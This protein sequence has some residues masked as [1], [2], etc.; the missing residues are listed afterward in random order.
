MSG[1]RAVPSTIELLISDVDG[2]LVT[3]NKHLT[4]RSRFAA[5]ALAEAGIRF[6][7][8]S[9]RPAIGLR[10]LIEPL[11]LTTPMGALNGGL[12][13]A[14]DGLVPIE[15]RILPVEVARR[16]ID[17]FAQN[18]ID[19]WLFDDHAWYAR[20]PSGPYVEHEQRTIQASP[21]IVE[22][23]DRSGLIDNAYKIVG[24]STDFERLAACEAELHALLGAEA[25]VARSQR[26]YLDI[27]HPEANKG[28]VVAVLSRQ[29]AIPQAAVACIGDGLNDIAMFEASALAVAMGNA[30]PAVQQRADF[31]TLS[32]EDD[33][34]AAAVERF[35][36]PRAPKPV[37]ANEGNPLAPRPHPA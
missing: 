21:V 15:E 3:S 16:S 11:H 24:V 28:R 34:F 29:L 35:I 18:G 14:P 31:V 2:T 32:N 5:R 19:V 1:Q 7:I 26:Y 23:F 30:S 9:S 4:P 37:S 20:N 22:T 13:V 8:T 6:A 10:M 17:Y 27:T 33:G 25:A 36:L 12:I